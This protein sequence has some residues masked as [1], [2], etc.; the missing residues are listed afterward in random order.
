[1]RDLFGDVNEWNVSRLDNFWF[2][3]RI[4][5]QFSFQAR[6]RNGAAER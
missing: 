1:V 5:E 4:D 6:D 3:A 2:A